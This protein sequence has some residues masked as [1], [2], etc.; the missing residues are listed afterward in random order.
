MS[1]EKRAIWLLASFVTGFPTWLIVAYAASKRIDRV[2]GDCEVRHPE[3]TKD[4]R[5][6]EWATSGKCKK[7]R[8]VPCKD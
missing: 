2:C 6:I 7:G 8:I 4:P 1:S 5:C 3:D